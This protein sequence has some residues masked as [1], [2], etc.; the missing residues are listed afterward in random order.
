MFWPGRTTEVTETRQKCRS[1]DNY[2]TS[3]SNLPPHE[4]IVPSYLFQ[5]ICADHLDHA[6]YS[7]GIIVNRFSNWFKVYEGKGG[8]IVFVN[9]RESCTMDRALEYTAAVTQDF[10]RQYGIKHRL[11]SVGNPHANS[12]A[13]I[14]VKTAKRLLRENIGQDGK[15]DTV[16]F[17]RAIMTYRNTRDADTGM[18]PAELLIGR[19]LKAFLPNK[20][21][22]PLTSNKDMS[23]DWNKLA[24]YREMALAKRASRDQ[25]RWS[26]KTKQL[27]DLDIG[28]RVAVQNQTGN[29]PK[30]WERR[31]IIVDKLL[32]DQYEVRLD[33]SRRITLCNRKFLRKYSALLQA[34]GRTII[35]KQ[36]FTKSKQPDNGLSEEFLEQFRRNFQDTPQQQQPLTSD[37][38]ETFRGS[39]QN[40]P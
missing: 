35:P 36:F 4:P 12:R 15:L 9:I 14:S 37:P 16:A 33:G 22:D 38:M 24:S 7:Y 5:H 10:F 19:Q 25:E 29:N 40:T 27:P 2:A 20:Y 6:G 17:T 34:N 39:F 3:P 32:Y 11:C 28:D 13:E 21:Y 30:R 1:C 26:E 8:A 31:R 23:S 18:C